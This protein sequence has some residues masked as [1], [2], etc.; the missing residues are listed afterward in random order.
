MPDHAPETPDPR[1]CDIDLLVDGEAY[2]GTDLTL[3]AA[4]TC[5]DGRDLRGDVVRILDRESAELGRTA[6]A[7]HEEGVTTSDELVVTAPDAPGEYT[8]TAALHAA[9]AQDHDPP[10]ATAS[11]RV[12][13]VAHPS[14]IEVWGVPA[15][16]PIG[17]RFRATVGIKCAAACDQAGRAFEILDHAGARV[18]DGVLGDA[19]WPGT[20]ALYHAE[21][22]LPA[23]AA[24][25]TYRWRV[26]SPGASLD[27]R[28]ADGE[29]GFGVV[30]VAPPEHVVT[31]ETVDQAKRTPIAG[32]HVLMH[33]FRALTDEQGIARLE[34]PAGAYDLYVSGFRYHPHRTRLEVD[35]DVSTRV[36]V[37]WEERPEK[38]S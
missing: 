1:P 3:T 25:G 6:L 5:P 28:H 32:M 38:I 23:P 19:P 10:W 2:A 4:V 14:R 26:R 21:V 30:A 8:W 22:Q 36:E 11:F 18:A 24:V 34:V 35:G 20:A 33:P 13:V 27:D 15:A 31:I 12:Q 37:A 9:D 17:T 29:R 7:E 16:T